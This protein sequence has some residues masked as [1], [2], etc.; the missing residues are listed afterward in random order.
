S[1]PERSFSQHLTLRRSSCFAVRMTTRIAASPASRPHLRRRNAVPA[2]LLLATVVVAM[3]VVVGA[4][5]SSSKT[6]SGGTGS[7]ST[8]VAKG[9]TADSGTAQDWSVYGHDLANTRLNP[10]ETKITA[11]TAS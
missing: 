4:C 10:N 9:S 3:A 6:E 2:G 1:L 8:T 7:T 11:A 5:S